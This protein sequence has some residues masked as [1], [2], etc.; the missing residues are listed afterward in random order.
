MKREFVNVPSAEMPN[1]TENDSLHNDEDESPSTKKPRIN[2]IVEEAFKTEIDVVAVPVVQET[3]DVVA[4]AASTVPTEEAVLPEV[5]KENQG[6]VLRVSEA[7]ETETR[8]VLPGKTEDS[9][10]AAK[11][12]TDD[13]EATVDEPKDDYPDEEATGPEDI[14]A[15]EEE[16]NH[17]STLS[18]MV[19]GEIAPK[20]DPAL[21]YKVEPVV[22]DETKESSEI[23]V[24]DEIDDPEEVTEPEVEEEV[25]KEESKQEHEDDVPKEESKQEDEDEIP[26][27]ETKQED[28]DE[29]PKEETKNEDNEEQSKEETMRGEEDEEQL[30]D[31]AKEEDKKNSDEVPHEGENVDGDDSQKGSKGEKLAFFL[32]GEAIEDVQL[33]L[34]SCTGSSWF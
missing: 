16:P 17:D 28:E 1:A 32:F 24:E 15:P 3:N 29:M 23:S 21:E 2:E 10:S 26:N 6:A 4:A 27:K 19:V 14:E 30:L 25:P 20:E 11:S 18:D 5:G 7:T 33:P 22:S 31:E 13:V 34:R 12:E 9:T 8:T